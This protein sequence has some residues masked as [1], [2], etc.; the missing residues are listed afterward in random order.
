MQTSWS[1]TASCTSAAATAE[2]TP[3]ERP[4]ITRAEP[5]C[6]RMRAT[7]S[8]MTLPLFQSAGRPAALVQEVLDD[9]LTVVGVL[10]LGVPLHAV[11]AALVAAERGDRRGGRRCEHVEAVGGLG[12]LVAVAHPHVLLGRLAGE[13]HAAVAR[14]RGIRRPV[15]AQAGVG[16]LAAE[17][18][19][20]HL[21]AVADAERRHAEVED[22]GVERRGARLVDRRR[23]AGEDDADRVLR[24]DVVGR[25]GVRDDL[26]V[27][28]RLAHAARD[29]LGV[30]RAEVDDEH[31]AL[32]VSVCS[33]TAGAFRGGL[34]WVRDAWT[35]C[36]GAPRPRARAGSA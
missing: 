2:S 14:E 3:P 19:R 15:L 6:S 9:P 30:L 20:H 34:A 10:D 16:D 27:D 8:A 33:V 5:T 7:C 11:Q 13:Q 36:G 25:R 1:P 4:Q 18:L 24:G 21:E 12:H 32:R 29:E 22:A 17:R 35:A 26:A 23:S 31:G 28:A